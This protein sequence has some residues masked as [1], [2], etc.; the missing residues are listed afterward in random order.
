MRTVKSGSL[1]GRFRPRGSPTRSR[2]SPRS[3]L[4]ARHP[5]TAL[6]RSASGRF[7]FLR[8]GS[9]SFQPQVDFFNIGNADTAV[10]T[11]TAVGPTY[12]RPTEILAPRIIRVGFSLNF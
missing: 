12:L 3:C 6:S 5:F 9:R 11:T 10:G 2:V 4:A 1:R 8:F 7:L